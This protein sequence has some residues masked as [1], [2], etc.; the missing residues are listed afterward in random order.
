VRD[1]EALLEGETWPTYTQPSHP[2][3]HTPSPSPPPPPLPPHRSGAGADRT[4]PVHIL[5]VGSGHGKL[6]FLLVRELV[7][8]W[9]SWPDLGTAGPDW[10]GP[11]GGAGGGFGLGPNRRLAPFRV[12]ISDFYEGGVPFWAQ[13]ESLRPFIDAGLVDFAVFDAEGTSASIGLRRSKGELSAATL[14]NPLVVVCNY[15]FDTLRQDAFRTV[16]GQLEEALASLY[17]D[18]HEAVEGGGETET[19][20]GTTA[21]G[22]KGKTPSAPLSLDPDMISRLRV[23]WSYRPAD[24]TSFG[25][26]ALGSVLTH[27]AGRLPNACPLLVPVGGLRLLDRLRALSNGRLFLLAGDKSYAHEEELVQ[28]RDPHVAIHGVRQLVRRR[29]SRATFFS[30]LSIPIFPPTLLQSFSF[31][32]N[33]HAVRLYAIAKG[34]FSLH[35]P[36]LDGFKCSAFVFG[37][38]RG[39]QGEAVASPPLPRSAADLAAAADTVLPPAALERYPELCYAWADGMDTFGPDNFLALQRCVR[40]ELADPSLRVAQGVLRM[41]Q[42]DPD[43]FFKFK[44]TFIDKAPAAGDRA[45]ADV[46]RDMR[47]VYE[48]YFPLQPSKDAAFDLGRVCMGLRRYPEAVALFMAS[49]RQCGEHHVTSYNAGICLF[50]MGQLTAAI[51]CFDHSLR[52]KA[53]YADAA[54]WR[55][56][57]EARI[58]GEVFAKAE[59]EAAAAAAAAAALGGMAAAQAPAAAGGVDVAPR[60]SAGGETAPLLT[61]A[62]GGGTGP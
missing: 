19:E 55:A 41:A 11:T 6:A 2:A 54:S 18:R 33:F 4:Q 39:A 56:R 42:W 52:L 48:R 29:R 24:P 59:A 13:H 3:S 46:Y 57:A 21:T 27:Y 32:V 44:A 47:R 7:E 30:H 31:M 20:T 36:Y 22:G 49:R 45:Q 43:V 8:A 23:T 58:A 40:D 35:T 62:G 17:T 60:D 53:D 12:V 50:H 37:G 38:M 15:I 1:G 5:E 16:D 9:Q 61:A 25:D 28:Q 26:D 10:T 51:A 34:G 14:R